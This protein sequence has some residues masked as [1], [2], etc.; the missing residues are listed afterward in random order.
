MHYVF[1][2]SLTV[3][4]SEVVSRSLC[5]DHCMVNFVRPHLLGT[6]VEFLNRFVN[7]ITNGQHL[8]STATDVQ[9]MKRRAHVLHQMLTGCIHV[10]THL[11]IID[12]AT[13]SYMHLTSSLCCLYD[14]YSTSLNCNPQASKV[15][16]KC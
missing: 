7:P 16:L 9:L 13:H 4:V 12:S 14:S 2:C 10:G 11:T 3:V 5:V 8:D 1:A 15:L 6:K